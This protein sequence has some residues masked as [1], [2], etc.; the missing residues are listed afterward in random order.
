MSKIIPRWE[1]RTFGQNFGDA[2]SKI[3]THPEKFSKTSEEQY[4]LSQKSDENVKIRDNL[5]D[6]KSLKQVNEDKLEQWFPAMKE[7]FPTSQAN[8][9]TLFRDFFKVNVPAFTKET[10][11]Y[12]EFLQLAAENDQLTVVEVEKERH[13]YEINEATVEIAETKFNGTP[14]RT[15]CVEHIDPAN[16]IATVRELGLAEFPNINYINAMKKVAWS[17]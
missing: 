9:V 5:V 16:V 17:E 4:I 13:I 3:K 10:Y 15:I 8:M 2:E 7:G 11:T 1:W 6:I 12:A 14:L